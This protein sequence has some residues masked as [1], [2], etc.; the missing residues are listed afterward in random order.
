V[1]KKMLSLG[2]P[3]F[4]LKKPSR[5]ATGHECPA[6]ER[7]GIQMPGT[8]IRSNPNTDLG[9]VFCGSLYSDALFQRNNHVNKRPVFKCLKYFG[10]PSCFNH[11]NTSLLFKWLT[12]WPS[13]IVVRTNMSSIQTV[14][15]SGVWY[16]NM[17]R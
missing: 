17:V 2:G 6:F 16:S 7:S 12:F 15:W 8:G 4:I 5:L 3:T 1:V 10:L 14:R 9:S 13:S 11:L